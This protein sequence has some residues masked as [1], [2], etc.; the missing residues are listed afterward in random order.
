LMSIKKRLVRNTGY[1]LTSTI[2]VKILTFV[3]VVIIARYLGK[4]NF[5]VFAAAQAFVGLFIV[6]ISLGTEFGFV[7]E[8]SKNK[9]IINSFLGSGIVLK[10]GLGVLSF[11]VIVLMARLLGYSQLHVAAISIFVLVWV[12]ISFQNFFSGVF[13]I[14]QRMEFRAIL[15][16]GRELVFF[17][18]LLIVIRFGT[19]V[20][21]IVSA[22][23]VSNVVFL[24]VAI[25]LSLKF[26]KPM[27]KNI[28][29]G[30][31]IK[32]SYLYAISGLFYMIYFQIDTVMLS[33]MRSS[34]ETGVYAAAYKLP[35]AAFLISRVIETVT[36]PAMFE[37]ES[38]DRSLL[39]KI[40]FVQTKYFVIFGLFVGISLWF[41]RDHIV[42]LIYGSEFAE[43]AIVLSVLA[44]FIP[45]RFVSIVSGDIITTMGKQ[46][47]RTM[48]QGITAGLNI[49]L[50][51]VLI[52]RYGLYGAAWST[53]CSELFLLIAY[54]FF[55]YRLFL[56]L[57]IIATF[58][59]PIIAAIIMSIVFIFA[60]VHWLFA[61]C[62]S[63]LSY[64]IMLFVMGSFKNDPIFNMI[65]TR[66]GR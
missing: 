9:E 12:F 46:N 59:K 51:I 40:Y 32:R 6:I 53:L 47:V 11:I 44:W 33:L 1:L 30:K 19:N 23:L 15:D 37:S 4:D 2:A 66:V 55:A 29:I 24:V 5:G 65:K 41:L 13:Q 7:Y 56:P 60:E 20:L 34:A 10:V 25:L 3:T 17:L 58:L 28:N 42:S 48:I 45:I 54:T 50:N 21:G 22:K 36:R 8:G 63:L 62:L 43:A 57:P 38:R 18:I 61:F 16:T 64:A 49:I 39:K 26:A 27:F 52:P 35:V 14:H 31:V